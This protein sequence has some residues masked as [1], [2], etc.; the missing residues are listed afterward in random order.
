MPRHDRHHGED[1]FMTRDRER[2]YRDFEDDR[3]YGRRDDSAFFGGE[4]RELNM[5]RGRR[6]GWGSLL[7]DE[8]SGSRGREMRSRYE[9]RDERGY[10]P[11][12]YNRDR[13]PTDE[14]E[15]LI[16]SNKVE[17][18]P[19]YDRN[20]DRLGSI[21]NFMVDKFRGKVVYAV[22]KHSS[23]FLGLDERYYPLDWD[24]LTYDQRLGGY[25]IAMTE[26]QLKQSGSWDRNE[27][28]GRM[29]PDRERFDRERDS[30]RRGE[31]SRDYGRRSMREFW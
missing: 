23:G 19:V 21:Q 20:G 5:R 15:R 13:I 8:S 18:T 11:D 9:S 16:S 28:W 22:L 6:G 27:R 24:Q 26:D 17:G 7:G 31:Y 3:D 1:D 29:L 2:S 12:D 10:G 25:H 4:S 30:E 14:T